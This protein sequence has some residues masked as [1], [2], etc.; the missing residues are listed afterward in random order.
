V[1]NARPD[2]VHPCPICS[3]SLDKQRLTL[4]V[5]GDITPD[6]QLTVEVGS[7]QD[8][9]IYN[10]PNDVDASGFD[11]P[12]EPPDGVDVFVVVALVKRVRVDRTAH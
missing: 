6:H 11:L 4:G 10:V 9:Q 7:S 12:V 5:Q 2:P 1:R 8:K 3:A